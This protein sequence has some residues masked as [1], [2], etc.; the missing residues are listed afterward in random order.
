VQT[1]SAS[2]SFSALTA[3]FIHSLP[4]SLS[5]H[6]PYRLSLLEAACRKGR[7]ANF[8]V[9]FS[10]TFVRLLHSLPASLP[11]A[12]HSLLTHPCQ[13]HR[14]FSLNGTQPTISVPPPLRSSPSPTVI[15]LHP[16][17]PNPL[18]ARSPAHCPAG[19]SPLVSNSQQQRR[20]NQFRFSHPAELLAWTS[21]LFL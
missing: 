8:E 19:D 6:N 10:G 11:P 18:R 17:L 3:T 7:R 2:R 13:H 15:R 12:S 14:P 1:S 5:L 20:V 9:A 16:K 21:K 4:L